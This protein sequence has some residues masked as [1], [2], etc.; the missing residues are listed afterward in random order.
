MPNIMLLI[1]SGLISHGILS[2]DLNK[3]TWLI[4]VFKIIRR[5]KIFA[6]IMCNVVICSEPHGM[7]HNFIDGLVQQRHNSIANA[8]ELRLSCTNLSSCARTSADRGKTDL[9]YTCGDISIPTWWK[10]RTRFP[11]LHYFC[12]ESNTVYFFISYQLSYT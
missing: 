5:N 6:L 12:V 11:S 7:P 9:W 1:L 4:E 2:I 3:I 8:L 10:I